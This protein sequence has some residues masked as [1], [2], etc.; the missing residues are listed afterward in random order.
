MAY[1]F[2]RRVSTGQQRLCISLQ[3]PLELNGDILLK[4][5]HKLDGGSETLCRYQF[6]T[7][8]ASS[9]R[10]S[11]NKEELDCAIGGELD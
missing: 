1:L 2:H 5:Y 8:T 4:F 3:V 11:A 9:G 10:L 6:N 7:S